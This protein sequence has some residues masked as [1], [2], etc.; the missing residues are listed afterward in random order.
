MTLST[1]EKEGITCEALEKFCRSHEQTYEEFL[2]SFIHLRKEDT[3]EQNTVPPTIADI[4]E[5]A[6][7]CIDMKKILTNS[8]EKGGQS[9]KDDEET[10]YE[11]EVEKCI[12]IEDIDSDKGSEQQSCTDATALLINKTKKQPIVETN[13]VGH[14]HEALPGKIREEIPAN[15]SH[16]ECKYTILDFKVYPCVEEFNNKAHDQAL[17][18]EVQPFTLDEE[19]DYNCVYLKPKYSE[20]E[21]KNLSALSQQQKE[22]GEYNAAK[23]SDSDL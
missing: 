7:K 9:S 2:E 10:R 16:C 5:D 14:C 19:F 23:L 1:M 13:I 3:K 15:Y 8:P 21:L 17:T 11:P 20:A 12:D 22:S 4:A 18:D 6:E